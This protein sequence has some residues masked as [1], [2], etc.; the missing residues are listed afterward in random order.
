[1]CADDEILES[2]V[3]LAGF[4]VIP[5]G[6]C[7]PFNTFGSRPMGGVKGNY[8]EI[9]DRSGGRRPAGVEPPITPQPITPPEG[10]APADTRTGCHTKPTTT[11]QTATDCR[12]AHISSLSR[13]SSVGVSYPV[14]PGPAPVPATA[15]LV[16]DAADHIDERSVGGLRGGMA[17]RAASD[18]QN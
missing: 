9:I 13:H 3:A 7:F 2:Y 16:G 18:V 1:V 8:E 17:Y 10:W 12:D 15:P 5:R 14:R 6:H 11:Q 4:V